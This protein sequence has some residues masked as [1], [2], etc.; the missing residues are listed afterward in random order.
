MIAL[1]QHK[2]LTESLL[3]TKYV[4]LVKHS[5][6][7][8]ALFFTGMYLQIFI[9]D[10]LQLNKKQK[11]GEKKYY[12]FYNIDMAPYKPYLKYVVY[13]DPAI[14]YDSNGREFGE[15]I[16]T[17]VVY[18]DIS[19]GSSSDSLHRVTFYG[20]VWHRSLDS[21]NQL[22][23]YENIRYWANSHIIAKLHAGTLLDT[24]YTNAK[25][26]WTL[27][28][29]KGWIPIKNLL[30]EEEFGEIPRWEKFISNLS[31][32][33]TDTRRA[34]GYAVQPTTRPLFKYKDFNWPFR[35]VVSVLF[36]TIFVGVL[37]RWYI[38]KMCKDKRNRLIN[39]AMFFFAGVMTGMTYWV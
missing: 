33:E 3:N 27:V 6:I 19:I 18:A 14:I 30:P 24:F 25:K 26:S 4:I 32:K 13:P 23:E 28:T 34:G 31:V 36:F 1:Y 17:P 35:L 15:A 29:F 9:I 8:A 11:L 37:L 20:W 21:N 7:L 22:T 2:S 39:A 38:P 16:K 5:I 12:E 10:F